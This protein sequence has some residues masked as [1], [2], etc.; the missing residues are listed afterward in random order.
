MTWTVGKPRK[1]GQYIATLLLPNGFRDL[2]PISV[3]ADGMA[4]AWHGPDALAL[5]NGA[6]IVAYYPILPVYNGA[7]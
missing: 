1:A 5:I 2:A 7:I 4:R 6:T 3:S